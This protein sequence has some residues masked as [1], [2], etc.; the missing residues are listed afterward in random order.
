MVARTKHAKYSSM[1]VVDLSTVV[2]AIRGRY[3]AISGTIRQM[4]GLHSQHYRTRT[5]PQFGSHTVAGLGLYWCTNATQTC[6]LLTQLTSVGTEA[7]AAL[8]SVT[9]PV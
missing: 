6:L 5:R 4:L 8:A 7:S 3:R 9:S 1:P 2:R